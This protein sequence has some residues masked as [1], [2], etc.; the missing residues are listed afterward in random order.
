MLSDPT[1]NLRNYHAHLAQLH[2]AQAWTTMPSRGVLKR[3]RERPAPPIANA[4]MPVP[5]GTRARQ[6]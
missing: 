5:V 2:P 3:Q 1:E 4:R 6:L